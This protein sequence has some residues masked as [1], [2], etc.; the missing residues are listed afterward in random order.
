MTQDTSSVTTGHAPTPAPG[1]PVVLDVDLEGRVLAR[2]ASEPRQLMEIGR[3]GQPRILT[4]LATSCTGLYIP[5]HRTIVV[6]HDWGGGSTP[7]LS[8]LNM[9]ATHIPAGLEGFH[10][11]AHGAGIT[12]RVLHVHHQG[13]TYLSDDRKRHTLDVWYRDWRSA[14]QLLHLDVPADARATTSKDGASVAVFSPDVSEITIHRLLTGETITVELPPGNIVTSARLVP[15]GSRMITTY[16]RPDGSRGAWWWEGADH[17]HEAR[18]TIGKVIPGGVSPD[19][20]H[21]VCLDEAT[22]TFVLLSI[23]GDELMRWHCADVGVTT[24]A[25]WNI[26]GDMCAVDSAGASGAWRWRLADGDITHLW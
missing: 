21:A 12:H 2:S 14:P 22:N 16:L 23:D 1:L 13:I 3:K 8:L 24:S 19:G 6:E 11:L 18:P 26:A 9:V 17:V 5:G 20:A 7:Q 15:D 10:L 25:A 4:S